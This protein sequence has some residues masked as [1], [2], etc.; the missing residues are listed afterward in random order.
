MSVDDISAICDSFDIDLLE[1]LFVTDR[2]ASLC[3]DSIAV[4][5]ELRSKQAM[6]FSSYLLHLEDQDK[7]GADKNLKWLMKRNSELSSIQK[8]AG[9]NCL[10]KVFKL[11]SGTI[12]NY[13]F[14]SRRM[15]QWISDPYSNNWTAKDLSIRSDLFNFVSSGGHSKKPVEKTMQKTFR[16]IKEFNLEDK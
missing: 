16:P 8:K 2:V 4:L 5:N 11:N 3:N 7:D 1:T 10:S 13:L 12:S 9:H 15:L 14:Y 6:L